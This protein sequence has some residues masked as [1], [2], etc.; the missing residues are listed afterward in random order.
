M[1]VEILA[2]ALFASGQAAVVIAAELP[3]TRTMMHLDA[4]MARRGA[5]RVSLR[6]PDF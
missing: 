5:G 3:A 1:A 4:V 2:K 6:S